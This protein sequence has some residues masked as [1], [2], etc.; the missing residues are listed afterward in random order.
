MPP[1]I[2]DGAVLTIPLDDWWHHNDAMWMQ[3]MDSGR[4]SLID[5]RVSP[6]VPGDVWDGFVDKTPILS[7]LHAK[8][9]RDR[10]GERVDPAAGIGASSSDGEFASDVI[11]QL[12]L[13][14]VVVFDAP[15]RPAD[16]DYVRRV[17]GGTENMVGTCAFF[18]L[19]RIRDTLGQPHSARPSE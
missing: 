18:E 4:Y 11:K 17:F 5:G 8:T 15:E 3:M 13:R 14:A 1:R 19:P 9:Q 16:V 10:P 12:D 2:R 7:F 6:Y